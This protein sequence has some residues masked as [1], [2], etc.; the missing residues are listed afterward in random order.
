MGPQGPYPS[1]LTGAPTAYMMPQ[2]LPP[3]MNMH[4]YAGY[5]PVYSLSMPPS[6]QASEIGVSTKTRENEAE[7]HTTTCSIDER[8]RTTRRGN[9]RRK[10]GGAEG[11]EGRLPTMKQ[12]KKFERTTT[13]TILASS[14]QASTE[15]LPKNSFYTQWSHPNQ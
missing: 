12:G 2:M 7:I 3:L 13:A 5:V 10:G 15:K 4:S 9:R 11:A 6:M 1:F 8:T 14:I